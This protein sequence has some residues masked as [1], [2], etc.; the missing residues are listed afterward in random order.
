MVFKIARGVL[1]KLPAETSHELS[2]LSIDAAYKT[3]TSFLVA[4]GR[5]KDKPVEVMGIT[6][7]NP[8]GLAAGLDKNGDHIDGLAALGFGFI[9]IGTVTPRSQPGNPK[10]RLFRLTEHNAIINRMG[11]NN[12]GVDHLVRQVKQ[13]KYRG[14]L[15]INIGKNKDTPLEN[16]LDDYL[17]CLRKVYDLASYVVINISSPNTPGLRHLQFGDSLTSLIGPLKEEQIKLADKHNRYVPLVVKIAPDL[18]EN[19]IIDVAKT[20]KSLK[21]DGVIATNTTSD[22]LGVESSEFAGE[23]GG[24]SGKPVFSKST[25]ALSVL[26]E[27]LAGTIPV[28]GLGG[29]HSGNDAMKKKER[30]ASLVQLYS[31]FIYEGPSLIKQVVT[32]WV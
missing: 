12:K 25:W 4:G 9:E 31:G 13:S 14:V 30:G 28:I 3:G 6:F 1:F 8:V 16:A 17:V 29:I 11:F 20:F 18:T 2:M 24:L 27:E 21:I 15:G 32:E 22:R 10:P 19:E 7:P 5:P 23:Q 26:C